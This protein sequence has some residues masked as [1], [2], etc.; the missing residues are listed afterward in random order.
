MSLWFANSWIALSLKSA[1]KKAVTS[2]HIF[3]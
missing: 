3:F 1:A 2:E